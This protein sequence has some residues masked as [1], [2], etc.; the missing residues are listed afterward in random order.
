MNKPMQITLPEWKE[1]MDMLAVND[2]CEVPPDCTPEKFAATVY[3]VKFN[4]RS[5]PP[6]YARDLYI[7]QPDIL[8]GKPPWVLARNPGKLRLVL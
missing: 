2:A 1:I 8:N 3:G 5:D 4:F 7:I 6:G